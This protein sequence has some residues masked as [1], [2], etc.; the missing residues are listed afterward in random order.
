MKNFSYLTPGKEVLFQDRN[1]PKIYDSLIPYSTGISGKTGIIGLP[2]S[3]TSISSSQA[4]EAPKTIRNCLKGFS[5]YSGEKGQD[6]SGEVILDFGDVPTHPANIEETLKRLRISVKEM[7]GTFS[8]ERH[9]ILGGDHGITFPAIQAFQEIYGTIGVIQWDAHHDVRSFE[10]GGRTN[11]TPF[12]SLIEGGF[13]KGEHLVQVGI[14]D[15]CNSKIYHEYTKKKGITVY[16]MGDVEETGIV[17][18]IRKE[19]SRLSAEA[20]LIYLSVDMDVVDQAYAP[21]CPAIGPGG[22]TSREL[23]K[24]IAEASRHPKVKAMDIVE[25]DPSRDFRDIT[26]RLASAAMLEFIFS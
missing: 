15:Y 3:R 10:D 9:I 22:L 14:R 2:Y 8:C 17:P 19:I 23:I 18:I 24:S 7:L 26:S 4:S 11:G 6:Y 25:I 12:R 13:I 5:A 16:S 21:G 20:D 1:M